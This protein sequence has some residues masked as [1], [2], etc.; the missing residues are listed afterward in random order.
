MSIEQTQRTMNRYFEAMRKGQFQQF[1]TDDVTWTTIESG[2]E[3]RGP[4]AVQAAIIALHRQLSDVHTR[5]LAVS[6]GAAY[7]EGD[8]TGTQAEQRRTAYCVAY[9]V[10][11]DRITAMRAYGAL[12]AMMHQPETDPPTRQH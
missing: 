3:V 6:D 7:I 9:D 8:G 4:S 2:D 1:F 10:D 5:R 11:D 12:A